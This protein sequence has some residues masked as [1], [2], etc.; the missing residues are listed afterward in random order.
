[1]K[2]HDSQD[3]AAM[4]HAAM[5]S[6]IGVKGH[7]EQQML[8]NEHLSTLWPHFVNLML[9]LWLI[10]APFAFGYLSAHTPDPGILRLAAERSLPSV[11][12]RNLYMTYSDVI[13]GALIILL[14]HPTFL[15][16]AGAG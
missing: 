13:S 6:S 1:M 8:I 11:E 14:I 4:V 16:V 2:S 3:H 9:G 15:W 7:D 12:T 5:P 10:T